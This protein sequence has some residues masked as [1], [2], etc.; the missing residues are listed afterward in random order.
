[1]GGP[2]KKSPET[3]IAEVGAQEYEP[4][5]LGKDDCSWFDH[6]KSEAGCE[7]ECC[8]SQENQRIDAQEHRKF[9][10]MRVE[11]SGHGVRERLVKN[12]S[13]AG[14]CKYEAKDKKPADNDRFGI[15]HW[16]GWPI[17]MNSFPIVMV[18]ATKA[19]FLNEGT[20]A[21]L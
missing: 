1:M 19:L 4:K 13:G 3:E 9:K 14:D 20:I 11:Q 21:A 15:R 2:D 8:D 10:T 17:H 18:P 16:D 7:T 5:A 12:T 6:P